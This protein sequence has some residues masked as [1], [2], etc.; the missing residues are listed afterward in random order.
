MVSKEQILNLLDKGDFFEVFEELNKFFLNK[1]PK[2]NALI[3]ELINPPGNFSLPQFVIRMK[4]F[5]NTNYKPSKT[6]WNVE[7]DYYDLLCEFDF[8]LQTENFQRIY[9]NKNI[10]AFLLHSEMSDQ[11]NDLKWLCKQLLYKESLNS[12]L[13]I[14][15][16]SIA[17]GSYESLLR[18]FYIK[19]GIAENA[20]TKTKPMVQLRSRIEDK[21]QN[22][23][24]VCVVKGPENILDSETELGIFFSEFLY[25]LDENMDKEKCAYTLIFIFVDDKQGGFPFKHTDY[26][27]PFNEDDEGIYL[28]KAI[29]SDEYRIIDLA[30]IRKVM[31]SDITNWISCSLKKGKDVFNK[32][33]CYRGMEKDIIEKGDNPYQVIER[34]CKD[35]KVTIKDTWKI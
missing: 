20:Q 19:F 10:A 32:I 4:V 27:L 24:L 17:G 11:E 7:I 8:K 28:K 34:I 31:E 5:V 6:K 12:D 2:L 33:S 26:F 3:D 18:E 25:Y 9:P 35:L 30:P 15:L 13:I 29:E 21:L 16:S 23:H 14:D 22:D 1:D